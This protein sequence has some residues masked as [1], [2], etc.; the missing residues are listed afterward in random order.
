MRRVTDSALQAKGRMVILL[1]EDV[2]FKSMSHVYNDHILRCLTYCP[3]HFLHIHLLSL[4]CCFLFFSTLNK[5]VS[6][7]DHYSLCIIGVMDRLWFHQIVL[8]S[9]PTASIAPK[10]IQ[11]TL[12]ILESMSYPSLPPPPDEEKTSDEPSSPE[13]QV[14]SESFYLPLQ[15][16][17]N[18][19]ATL[20][21]LY[22]CFVHSW[23]DP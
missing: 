23:R 4:V 1:T 18:S 16:W 20:N 19:N 15:V 17:S 6:M 3:T 11:T 10:P 2:E 12:P 5:S 13:K 7:A 14:L 22:L 8:F 9:E 21:T